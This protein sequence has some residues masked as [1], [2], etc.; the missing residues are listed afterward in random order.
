MESEVK[1]VEWSD[2]DDLI[3]EVIVSSIIKTSFLFGFVQFS[4][5]NTQVA[6]SSPQRTSATAESKPINEDNDL[7]KEESM[8]EEEQD[9]SDDESVFCMFAVNKQ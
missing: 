4:N 8:M 2:E 6:L 9:F 7:T 3:N 1:A 5:S